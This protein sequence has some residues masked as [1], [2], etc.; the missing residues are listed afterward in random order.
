MW[1]HKLEKS[2][3]EGVLKRE[4]KAAWVYPKIATERE[5]QSTNQLLEN[6]ICFLGISINKPYGDGSKLGTQKYSQY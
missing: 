6:E 3:L 2:W 4:P 1:G 5:L